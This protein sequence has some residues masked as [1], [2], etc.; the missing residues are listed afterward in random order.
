MNL[1]RPTD[2]VS[3]AAPVTVIPAGTEFWRVHP[4][5]YLGSAPNPGDTPPKKTGRFTHFG[6]PTV[7]AVYAANTE[8]NAIA[9]TILHDVPIKPGSYVQRNTI[10]FRSLTPIKNTT[11][12]TVLALFGEAFREMEVE[13]DS[14]TRLALPDYS[15]TVP[16]GQATFE[17]KLQG[18]EW[19]SRHID[20]DRSHVFYDVPFEVDQ[21]RRSRDFSDPKDMLWI[22]TRLRDLK[23][24][25]ID[26]SE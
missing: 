15:E 7:K 23:V 16:W 8:I 14:L 17:A 12:V 9:E 19:V 20:T 1:I 22:T 10:E 3:V 5:R 24:A 2:G 21:D 6:R 11:D 13:P 26:P 18:I 4:S 25:V